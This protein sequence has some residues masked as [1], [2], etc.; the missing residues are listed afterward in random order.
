MAGTN[1]VNAKL[2]V[3]TALQAA[4]ADTEVQVSYHYPGR[5]GLRELIH[6]GRVEGSHSYFAMKGSRTRHAREEDITFRLFV[7]VLKPGEDPYVAEAR[8]VELGVEIEHALSERF[9][10]DGIPG[11]LSIRVTAVDIDS[12]VEDEGAM[13]VL[14][15][16]V[17]C[18][19]VVQ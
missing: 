15:Y 7:C 19:S 4:F 13:A 12:D 10:L 1:A 18:K 8:C 14:T 3:I 9:A 17:A 2:A 16:D 11:L 5:D 6:A